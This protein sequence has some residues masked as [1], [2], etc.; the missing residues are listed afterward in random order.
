MTTPDGK[1]PTPRSGETFD[2]IDDAITTLGLLRRLW[3]GDSRKMIHLVAS[4]IDQAQRCLPETGRRRQ[5]PGMQLAGHRHTARREPATGP[6][7]IRPRLTRRGQPLDARHLKTDR[8][9]W[10]SDG[11]PA[12]MS[13]ADANIVSAL[14][15]ARLRFLA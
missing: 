8:Q 11:Y 15:P 14:S 5:R 2:V 3:M 1:L 7:S 10:R 13:L 4:L 9:T 6:A 12:E